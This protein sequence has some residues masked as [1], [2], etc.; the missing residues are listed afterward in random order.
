ML[1]Q[2]P[3]PQNVTTF[4]FRLIGEMTLKQFGYLAAGAILAY[5]SFNLPVP[6]FFRY[7][8]TG[9]FALGGIGFAFVP[10]EER[11][12]DVWFMSFIKS[13]YS[14]TQYL[15][16]REDPLPEPVYATNISP[17]KKLTPMEMLA[18]LM[19]FS[20]KTTA[21]KVAPQVAPPIRHTQPP[22]PK[23]VPPPTPTTP[24]P[25]VEPTHPVHHTP[26]TPV[27]PPKHT[28]TPNNVAVESAP[29]TTHPTTPKPM[30]HP[31]TTPPRFVTVPVEEP[32]A[33]AETIAALRR[34]IEDMSKQLKQQSTLQNEVAQLK[35]QLASK[36]LPPSPQTGTVSEATKQVPATP[37]Q[38]LSLTSVP[39][40]ISG[41]V[42]DNQ[43]S[44]LTGILITVK[45]NNG[46]PVRALK[47][48]KLGQFA[49]S[50][51]LP[52]GT[53]TL[54]IEDPKGTYFFQGTSTTLKG[55]V[56][57][58]IIVMAQTQQQLERVKLEQAVFGKKNS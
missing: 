31:P 25:T 39:N 7:P 15:W 45:D 22:A 34:Q 12:M 36:N 35:S 8:L 40:V 5:I 50:T 48:N 37:R 6:F 47:T 26:P 32:P 1:E 43:G 53:Y 54:E 21:S 16:Q 17:S 20:K 4:Q 33:V 14:P 44:L 11:P 30:S 58:S 9:I 55:G 24:P 27:E 52:D 10:I 46:I 28:S 57:P 42:R 41:I 3:I 51:P 38:T 29:P 49:A 2:H 18:T 19:P 23:P 13:I 56:I